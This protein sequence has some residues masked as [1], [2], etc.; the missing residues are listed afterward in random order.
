MPYVFANV[1]LSH[2]DYRIVSHSIHLYIHIWALLTWSLHGHDSLRRCDLQGISLGRQ[3]I[4]PLTPCK[5]R[6]INWKL[7]GSH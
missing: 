1:V 6:Q 7:A 5:E 4:M 2:F 3:P